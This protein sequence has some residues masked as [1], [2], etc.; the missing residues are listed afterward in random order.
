MRPRENVILAD[1]S[2]TDHALFLGNFAVP[3]RRAVI[4]TNYNLIGANHNLHQINEGSGNRNEG[5]GNQT[6][7]NTIRLIGR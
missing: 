4:V 5:S 6:G 7:N 3:A 2:K 1:I